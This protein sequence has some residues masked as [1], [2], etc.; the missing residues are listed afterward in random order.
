MILSLVII[1]LN[2]ISAVLIF[3]FLI[4]RKLDR[5]TTFGRFALLVLVFGLIG[6][7]L[8]DYNH[9]ATGYSFKDSEFWL[10]IFKDIGIFLLVIEVIF[11]NKIAPKFINF[12]KK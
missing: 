2:L 6:Q 9:V 7:V 4:C 8:R 10:W 11:F 12:Y 3:N 1:F 5:S